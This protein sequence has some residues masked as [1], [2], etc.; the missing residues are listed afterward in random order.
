MRNIRG[1]IK[2]TGKPRDAYTCDKAKHG[3]GFC[4]QHT[5][6]T[7]TVK[8]LVLDTLRTICTYARE[9]EEEF[10]RQVNEMFSAQ[11]ADTVKAQRKKLTASQK[12]RD[13]LDRL[14]QNIY[15][16]K[17]SGAL[18][19]KRYE[20]LSAE[21]EREQ[22]ELEQTITELQ[23][24]VDSFDDSAARAESFL[25]LT[26]RYKDF[27]E[28]TAPMLHEFIQKIVVHERAEP[29]VRCTSQKVEIHLNFIGEYEL[30][31]TA[32]PEPD[33]AEIAEEERLD[34]KRKWQR[35]YRLRRKENGGK[36]LGTRRPPVDPRTPEQKA[37]DD[38]ARKVKQKEYQ[39]EYQREW[40]RKKAQERR[41]AKIATAS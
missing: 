13:D 1:I 39:R 2:A 24:A 10:S 15:E 19:V 7:S 12:R 11:Q 26:R 3:R 16:D 4:T 41:D 8:T 33:P 31:I 28:L 29:K 30:P 18:P 25:E 9:N 37:A 32:L 6:Q 5:I 38:A 22:A 34:T 27:N 14:I 40:Q 36:P 17:V 20:V 21:Y 35:E 23:T